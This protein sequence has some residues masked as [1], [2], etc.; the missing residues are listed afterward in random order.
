MVAVPDIG[1]EAAFAGET[2]DRRNVPHSTP[3]T[4]AVPNYPNYRPQLPSNY[5]HIAG[6]V[7]SAEIIVAGFAVTFFAGELYFAGRL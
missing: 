6:V 3:I 7:P 5:L 1:P 2:R 4:P